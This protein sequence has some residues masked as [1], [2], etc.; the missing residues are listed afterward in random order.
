MIWMRGAYPHYLR[1]QT[2]IATV[3]ATGGN[4]PPVASATLA[5]PDGPGPLTVDL[6]ASASTDE[7]G[8]VTSYGWDFGDGTVRPASA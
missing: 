1:F 4:L 5:P 3:L 2:S 8:H 7:D 6:D